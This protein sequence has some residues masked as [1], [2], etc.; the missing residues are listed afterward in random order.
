MVT[1]LMIGDNLYSLSEAFR[2]KYQ[3]IFF[4]SANSLCDYL[5]GRPNNQHVLILSERM[6]QVL[7]YTDVIDYLKSKGLIEQLPIVLLS[8]DDSV[9]LRQEAF[10]FG[11]SDVIFSPVD[12]LL[13]DKLIEHVAE[14]NFLIKKRTRHESKT[15]NNQYFLTQNKEFQMPLSKRIFD[16]VV[17]SI[18]LLAFMPLFMLIAIAIKLE[19]QGP[20]FYYSKRVGTGYKIFKFWKFRSMRQDADQLIDDLKHLNHYAAEQEEMTTQVVSSASV[21]EAVNWDQFLISDDQLIDEH[22]FEK[23][24]AS[25]NKNMFIKIPDD[26]RITRVGKL[27]RNTSMDELPQLFNVLCGD[28]SLVGNRPLP[29][30]EAE[31][32]TSDDLAKRFMAPAGITGLWQVMERGKSKTSEESRKQLDI[33]YAENYSLWL[34]IKILLKTPLAAIQHENV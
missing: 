16:I 4:S 13:F 10:S 34:D 18:L 26:P 24:L 31:K 33:E 27:I 29:L 6:N 28:M 15:S 17:S 1:L 30:Y 5:A 20:V 3:S 9:E 14:L 11:V 2:D 21:D 7:S 19:S 22:T 25:E 23:R 32:L 8:Q 12:P